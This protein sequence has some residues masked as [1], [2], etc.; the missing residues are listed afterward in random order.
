MNIKVITAPDYSLLAEMDN[1][2]QKKKHPGFTT[3]F[4]AGGISNC[5]NWQNN[6]IN[7]MGEYAKRI[8]EYKTVFLLNPRRENFDVSN[9][10]ESIKQIDWEYLHLQR[11][12]HVLFWFPKDTLCPITLFELG[13]CLTRFDPMDIVV[14]CDPEYKRLTDVKRQVQLRGHRHVATSFEDFCQRATNLLY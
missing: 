13:A 7:F 5:P 2:I 10:E 6:L 8:N 1:S 3:L 9:D 4:L 11:T 14:G 12:Q